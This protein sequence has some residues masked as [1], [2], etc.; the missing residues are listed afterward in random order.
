VALD[1][2]ALLLNCTVPLS[3]AA[4]ST[5][6]GV[7]P[8]TAKVSV[9]PDARLALFFTAIPLSVAALGSS[10]AAFARLVPLHEDIAAGVAP[11]APQVLQYRVP[12]GFWDSPPPATMASAAPLPPFTV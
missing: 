3:V 9:A 11:L 8:V 6:P 5:L 7:R 12:E 2:A 1:S 4:I 10:R